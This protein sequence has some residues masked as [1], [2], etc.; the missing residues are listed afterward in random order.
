MNLPIDD[1]YG[2]AAEA[3][4]EAIGKFDK[5]ISKLS[6][7]MYICI[8]NAILSEISA[9]SAIK[10]GRKYVTISYNTSYHSNDDGEGVELIETLTDGKIFEINSISI[11]FLQSFLSTL[12][13][14]EKIVFIGILVG[15]PSRVIG[16]YLG[17]TRQAT[18]SI[19]KKIIH[20]YIAGGYLV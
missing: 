9:T 17:I 8:K 12:T 5:D 19:K 3:A 7:Y 16:E 15:K 4:C 18:D 11:C 20:K 10:R 13:Q 2:V 14:E 6:T 1:Y